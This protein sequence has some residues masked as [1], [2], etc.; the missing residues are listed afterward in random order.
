MQCA[1][2]FL[3]EDDNFSRI[4]TGHTEEDEDVKTHILQMLERSAEWPLNFDLATAFTEES[5]ETRH[6][7][8]DEFAARM[9]NIS[10]IMDCVRCQ[11]CRLWGKLQVMGLG[12]AL[13]IMYA[14]DQT[15]VLQSLQRNHIVALFNAL[16][17][18]SH[19]VEAS[20][21]IVP[22]LSH[23]DATGVSTETVVENEGGENGE[24]ESLPFAM[25]LGH[26]G[27]FA[28]KI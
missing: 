11:R 16:G 19:S 13:R 1:S 9:Y 25:K 15:V 8:L 10:Q 23:A 12:V 26:G 17:R 5:A 18:L 24:D 7:L 27:A 20:R 28:V 3:A 6:E 21:V 2:T 14:P 4:Q 22:L